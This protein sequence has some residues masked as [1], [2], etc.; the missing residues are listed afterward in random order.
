M[1]SRTLPCKLSST[2]LAGQRHTLQ[3]H[4]QSCRPCSV[5]C[6]SPLDELHAPLLSSS[7]AGGTRRACSPVYTAWKALNLQ[8]LQSGTV[9]LEA[10]P[11]KCCLHAGSTNES[12]AVQ[13]NVNH[14]GS[15][16]TSI[17]EVPVCR[18]SRGAM[19]C[20]TVVLA[21]R[22]PL[23][24]AV[25]WAQGPPDIFHGNLFLLSACRRQQGA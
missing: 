3:D 21:M 15:H 13:P 19:A 10:L 16:L 25:I 2:Q 4:P 5:P 24:A 22:T 6:R 1:L 20:H 9:G 12:Q 18:D 17:L 11:L 14:A 23:P 8:H 7:G